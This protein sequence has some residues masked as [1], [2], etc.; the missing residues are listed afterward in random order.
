MKYCKLVLL[1]L[2]PMLCGCTYTKT[3][4]MATGP[5]P[6][7]PWHI[8]VYATANVPFEYEELGTVCTVDMNYYKNQEAAMRE[9]REAV[10]QYRPDAVINFRFEPETYTS[11]GGF[12]G[13]GVDTQV[14]GI[15]IS[16]VAVKIKRP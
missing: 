9:F 15:R 14:L 1:C 8:P 6:V 16:G 10:E 3:L 11:G 4:T 2:L 12:L 7:P 13:V 5:R